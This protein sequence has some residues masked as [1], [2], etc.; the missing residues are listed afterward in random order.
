[1]RVDFDKVKE[2]YKV[3]LNKYPNL[4]KDEFKWLKGLSYLL[5]SDVNHIIDSWD[6]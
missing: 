3:L 2:E 1:M 5:I 6:N 4:T